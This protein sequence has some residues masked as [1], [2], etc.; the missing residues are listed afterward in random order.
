MR[1]THVLKRGD[2]LKPTKAVTP[3]VPAFLHPL[4]EK[5]QPTSRLTL[6][7]W[8]VDRRS[9]TTARAFVNRL[10]QSYFGTGIVSTS[11]D[12]GTQGDKPSPPEL[13]DGMAVEFTEPSAPQP[14]APKSVT[15]GGVKHL[16]RLV[17]L[18]A[19]YRQS[20]QVTPALLQKDPYNRLIARG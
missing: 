6:A 2:F 13:R 15:P 14:G 12:L 4:A 18:S 19:A 20:S 17:V 9:P 8:L 5:D 1:P 3:G 16:H 10:W 7:R 11:E